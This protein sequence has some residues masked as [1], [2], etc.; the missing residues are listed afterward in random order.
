[1]IVRR[2]AAAVGLVGFLGAPPYVI[3]RLVGNPILNGMQWGALRSTGTLDSPTALKLGAGL[4]YLVWCWLTAIALSEIVRVRQSQPEMTSTRTWSPANVVRRLVRLALATTVTTAAIPVLAFLPRSAPAAAVM[5]PPRSTVMRRAESSER[6]WEASGRD[7]ALSVSIDVFGTEARRED[8]VRLNRGR[9]SPE[10]VDWQSGPFPKGM[11]ILLPTDAPA[12]DVA[13]PVAVEKVTIQSGDNLWT[14]ARGRLDVADGPASQPTDVQIADYT[15]EVIAGNADVFVQM[16]N[17]DLIIPGQEFAF[18]ALGNGAEA[19]VTPTGAQTSP[20]SVAPV[21]T[22]PADEPPAASPA[23]TVQRT[24]GS[25]S[26]TSSAHPSPSTAPI[27]NGS[28]SR[29]TATT[30]APL[31]P[32]TISPAP[33]PTA[34]SPAA[35]SSTPNPQE[36]GHS[37]VPSLADRV[38]WL[39]SATLAA[40]LL[41]IAARRRRGRP[42][43]QRRPTEATRDVD[44]ALR[45]T[46]LIDSA[47]WAADTLRAMPLPPVREGCADAK[48]EAVQ[49]GESGLEVLWN[50][51]QPDVPEGWTSVNAGWSWERARTTAAGKAIGLAAYPCLVTIGRREGNDVLINLEAG[52]IIEIMGPAAT[53]VARAIVLELGATLHSD[54]NVTLTNASWIDGIEHI[55]GVRSAPFDEIVNWLDHHRTTFA[56]HLTAAAHESLP[57]LR[58][59]GIDTF[60]P[61]VAVIDAT[62]LAD[63]DLDR[64]LAAAGA[65]AI[66]ILINPSPPSGRGWQLECTTEQTTVQPLGVI[67]TPT[68]VSTSTAESIAR[69][70]AELDEGSADAPTISHVAD[71]TS[72]LMVED[73][74]SIL[75]GR[76]GVDPDLVTSDS[77]LEAVNLVEGAVDGDPVGLVEPWAIQFRV[78]GSVGC[79][80]ELADPLQPKELEVAIFMALHRDGKTSDTIRTMVWP[81]QIADQRWHNLTTR[82]RQKLGMTVEGLPRLPKPGADLRYRL[83]DSVVTDWDLFLGLARAAEHVAA[84]EALDHYGQALALVHGAP[85]G[86]APAGYSWAYSDG[87]FTEMTTTIVAVAQQATQIALD[88]DDPRTA[89]RLIGRAYRAVD[90]IAAQ[91]LVALEMQSQVALGL[92]EKAAAAFD[93]LT[94]ELEGDDPSPAV[95]A[96]RARMK[97]SRS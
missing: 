48:L 23:I 28:L 65:G 82:I 1:M 71:E 27:S 93:V 96:M 36:N 49:V 52:G 83:H 11:R 2:L 87:T 97:M 85:F 16:G 76:Y 3:G 73:P 40:G 89:L 45:S 67:V 20:T 29:P 74:E 90:R 92:P 60:E 30:A 6:V 15:D 58:A 13:V 8:I 77:D 91:D 75:S 62:E 33:S 25:S 86:D 95:A 69:M 38:G 53:D 35:V 79:V 19:P 59:D 54:V 57:R 80:T 4:F 56:G 51:P 12:V 66:V 5:A 42:R 72:P 41:A 14:L 34:V 81:D 78:L 43:R 26:P 61:A 7:T 47:S 88:L 37:S 46:P 21:A 32:P 31:P 64:V 63:A 22:A 50:R 17:A 39:G 84:S 94:L 44:L 55:T 24:S 18:P 10:G 68:S 70:L 9:T